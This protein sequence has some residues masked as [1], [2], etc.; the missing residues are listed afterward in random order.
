MFS[1]PGPRGGVGRVL[2]V[3]RGRDVPLHR[4]RGQ[5]PQQEPPPRP[6]L[7]AL[8]PGRPHALRPVQ[9]VQPSATTAP[10]P[11]HYC[12]CYYLLLSVVSWLTRIK[13]LPTMEDIATIITLACPWCGAS[14]QIV[15]WDSFHDSRRWCWSAAAELQTGHYPNHVWIFSIYRHVVSSEFH[16]QFI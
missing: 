3:R 12:Y 7:H 1:C 13:H 16:Y 8:R 14:L 6:P 10:C 4:V 11:V 15:E 9:L 2:E 5:P